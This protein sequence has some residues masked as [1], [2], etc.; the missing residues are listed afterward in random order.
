MP[1]LDATLARARH[2]LTAANR[3]S[4]AVHLTAFKSFPIQAE[5]TLTSESARA[6]PLVSADTLTPKWRTNGGSEGLHVSA[7][8]RQ[9]IEVRSAAR[10]WSSQLAT[11]N[12]SSG[13]CLVAPEYQPRSSNI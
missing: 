2:Y 8:Y 6:E 3:Y 4:S 9:T 7:R 12:T 5:R 10:C 1:A 11:V 13:L